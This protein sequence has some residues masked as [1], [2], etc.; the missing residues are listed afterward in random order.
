M[1][2]EVG[3]DLVKENKGTEKEVRSVPGLMR[4][5]LETEFGVNSRTFERRELD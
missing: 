4:K 2:K 5:L 3:R 1:D